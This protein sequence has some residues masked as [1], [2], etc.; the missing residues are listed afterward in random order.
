MRKLL[1]HKFVQWALGIAIVVGVFLCISPPDMLFFKWQANFTVQIMLIYL[2]LGLF[3]LLL[4]QEKLVYV[5]FISC[6]FLCLFLRDSL[7]ESL[8]RSFYPKMNEE[9]KLEIA[10][11]NTSAFEDDQES[12]IKAIRESKADLVAIQEVTPDWNFMLQDGLYD[13]YEHNKT[14][15][16]IDFYGMAVYSKHPFVRIDTFHFGDIPNI[17]GSIKIDS[18]HGEIFFITSHTTP[19]VNQKAYEQINAHLDL[20]ADYV[21]NLDAPV[22]TI[23]GYNMVPWAPEMQA[24]R[25]KSKLSNSRRGFTPT[26][27]GTAMPFL[28]IPI[29]HILYSSDFQCV[30]FNSISSSTSTGVGIK[31]KFQFKYKYVKGTF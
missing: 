5:S 6:G 7:D 3:F 21:N 12:L 25:L 8:T 20:I 26:S 13:L 23:G 11:F 27:Q 16:R 18:T 15:R 22:F 29:D 17:M 2:A 9:K 14:V 1:E 31:G 4:R 10:H 30:A 19:P 28:E 24:F